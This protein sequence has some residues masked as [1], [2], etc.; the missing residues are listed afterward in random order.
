MPTHSRA[1]VYLNLATVRQTVP[2]LCIGQEEAPDAPLV[3]REGVGLA[4]PVIEIAD[5]RQTIRR[6]R[7]LAIPHARL[8]FLGAAVEPE[9]P[10]SLAD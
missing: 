9:I 8:P 3:T 5:Q 4:V 10:M 1:H 6:W 2:V 7:P